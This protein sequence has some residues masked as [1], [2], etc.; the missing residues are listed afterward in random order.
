MVLG[1]MEISCRSLCAYSLAGSVSRGWLNHPLATICGNLKGARGRG[2]REDIPCPARVPPMLW[3]VRCGKAARRFPLGPGWASKPLTPLDRGG[4][5]RGSP[6]NQGPQGDT[7]SLEVT[8]KRAEGE[9]FPL[10]QESSVQALLYRGKPILSSK[11]SG[12]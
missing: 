4:G 3:A 9:K 10:R 12:P 11:R 2:E 8:G 5:T 6:R 7:L 1:N